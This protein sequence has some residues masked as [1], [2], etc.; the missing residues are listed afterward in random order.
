MEKTGP[1]K[2][3]TTPNPLET[4]ARNV[5]VAAKWAKQ[6]GHAAI[7]TALSDAAHIIRDHIAKTSAK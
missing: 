6:M 5:A 3:L 1:L 7:A 4:A 2:A